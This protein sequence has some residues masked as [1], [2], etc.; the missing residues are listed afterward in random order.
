MVTPV[1][2]PAIARR[3]TMY[4]A[5]LEDPS[6]LNTSSADG[7]CSWLGAPTRATD[8]VTVSG[9]PRNDQSPRSNWLTGW[10]ALMIATRIC[11]DAP[12]RWARI[13]PTAGRSPATN[14]PGA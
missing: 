4:A 2:E 12:P 5:R 13:D 1:G 9:Y 8:P 3:V 10:A 7:W 14:A 11:A 6:R